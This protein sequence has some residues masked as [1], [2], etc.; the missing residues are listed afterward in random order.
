MILLPYDIPSL[1]SAY[2]GNI[3]L[4]IFI[5]FG[6]FFNSWAFHN[7]DFQWFKQYNIAKQRLYQPFYLPFQFVITFFFVNYD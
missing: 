2:K 5:P 6:E 4:T 7:I 1:V 3:R